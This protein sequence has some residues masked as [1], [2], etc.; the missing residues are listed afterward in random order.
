MQILNSY[1]P[2][3]NEISQRFVLPPRTVFTWGD[4]IY[5][6]DGIMI[7]KDLR[8]HEEVHMRQQGS[9]PEGWWRRY[10]DDD[11]FRLDQEREAYGRQ[12]QYIC[13]TNLNPNYRWKVLTALAMFLASPMYGNITTLGAAM[14]MIRR[15]SAIIKL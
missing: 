9:S 11:L 12:Y 1:P 13:S 10:L 14:E 15:E 5:N 8:A 4:K 6:P 7:T 2:N 3:Y